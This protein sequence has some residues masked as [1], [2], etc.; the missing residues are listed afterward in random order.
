MMLHLLII[1]FLF[2]DEE[3]DESGDEVSGDHLRTPQTNG[4][5]E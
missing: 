4:A 3:V 5:D 1:Y 2:Q